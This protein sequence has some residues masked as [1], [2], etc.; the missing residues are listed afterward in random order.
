MRRVVIKGEPPQSWIDKAAAVAMQLTNATDENHRQEIIKAKEFL[1][2]KGEIR[3]WLLKQFNDKCWYS[4]ARDSVATPQVEHFRPKGRVKDLDGKYSESYWWLAFDWRNYRIAGQRINAKKQDFFPLSGN[5]RA[6]PHDQEAL[7]FESPVLL[8]PTTDQTRLVSYEKENGEICK[9]VA[10][11]G[12]DDGDAYRAETTIDILGLNEI[13][14]LFRKRA[15]Y[16]DQCEMAIAEYKSA[17]GPQV[18]KWVRRA[19]ALSKLK[20]MVTYEA[21]FSSVAE[22]CIRKKAP[23]SVIA[24]VFDKANAM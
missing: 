21:E 1:W 9:A 19:S 17:S 5:L 23:E 10:A 13:P 8:D 24:S 14:P 20:S 15:A 12:I 22:A 7:R 2:R 4:E 16:W 18:L 11:A 6:A 3:D